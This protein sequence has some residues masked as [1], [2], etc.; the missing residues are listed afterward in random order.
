MFFPKLLLLI[1]LSALLQ[2][3]PISAP[4]HF[5]RLHPAPTPLS[6]PSPHWCLCPWVTHICS[7]ANLFTFCHPVPLWQLSICFIC[8]W[9]CFYHILLCIMHTFLQKF[10]RWNKDAH[11][12]WVV[13]ITYLYKYFPF[14][15]LCLCVKKYNSIK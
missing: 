14:F 10:L 4:C 13:L 5:A 1:L 3:S 15:Y 6:W 2:M 12:T 8:P 11:Y 7:L 9:L